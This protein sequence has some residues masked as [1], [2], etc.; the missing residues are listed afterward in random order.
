MN[1]VLGT[2]SASG[3]SS[4]S[5]SSPTN[6]NSASAATASTSTSTSTSPSTGATGD[7][8]TATNPNPVAK[9]GA[10]SGV[11]LPNVQNGILDAPTS[12]QAPLS[13]ANVSPPPLDL[14]N[15]S[16]ALPPVQAGDVVRQ[17]MAVAGGGG[18]SPNG[19]VAPVALPEPGPVILLAV[20]SGAYLGRN[21]LRRRGLAGK[22][23]S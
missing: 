1:Q 15:T 23:S 17:S 14:Q 9:T 19:T 21:W 16:T 3:N 4:G 20:A 10:V 7:H 18:A 2:P 11:A 22:S 12:L 8:I 13:V 5:S 6:A